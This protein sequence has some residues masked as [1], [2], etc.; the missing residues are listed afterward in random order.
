[1]HLGENLERKRENLPRKSSELPNFLSFLFSIRGGLG[2]FITILHVFQGWR[3]L[4][5]RQVK[6]VDIKNLV[7]FLQLFGFDFDR[8]FEGLAEQ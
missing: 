2:V 1:M 4:S 5:G 8:I 6:S 7:F 3:P